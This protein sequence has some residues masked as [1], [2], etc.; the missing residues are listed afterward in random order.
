VYALWRRITVCT[1]TCARTL[2][3][4]SIPLIS[5]SMACASVFDMKL[6]LATNTLRCLAIMIHFNLWSESERSRGAGT[7]GIITVCSGVRSV[8][9]SGVRSV[10]RSVVCSGVRSVVILHV[11]GMPGK[12][13]T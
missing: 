9:C 10:V 11:V 3:A 5:R 12:I 4:A 2:C 13:H 6:Q 1:C 8:V 7:C